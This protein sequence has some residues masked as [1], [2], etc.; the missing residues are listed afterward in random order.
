MVCS[1]CESSPH[2]T[3]FCWGVTPPFAGCRCD[4]GPPQCTWPFRQPFL[5]QQ[6]ETET[7][8]PPCFQD[9]FQVLPSAALSQESPGKL[10]R[11]LLDAFPEF[12][13]S[14][15]WGER[16]GGKV[17]LFTCQVILTDAGQ[18]LG[19]TSRWSPHNPTCSASL[20]VLRKLRAEEE[21]TWAPESRQR[22]A[23]LGPVP[24]PSQ[25]AKAQTAKPSSRPEREY[26]QE[27]VRRHWA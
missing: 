14:G 19:V 11:Y 12:L 25:P 13:I 27:G 15:L 24:A 17:Y 16:R 21:Y 9:P 4:F 5:T 2:V 20:T 7:F 1:M 6:G 10:Y 23:V 26:R 8:L 18:W 22:N 3:L